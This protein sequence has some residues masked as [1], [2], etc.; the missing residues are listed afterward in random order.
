MS[1]IRVDVNQALRCLTQVEQRTLSACVTYGQVAANKMVKT[2]KQT[3]PW[4]DHTHLA[5]NSLNGGASKAGAGRVRIEL[6]H[7][8]HYGVYLELKHFRHKGN[9]AIVFPTVK[10]MAPEIIRGWGNVIRRG[11]A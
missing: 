7:G 4:T 8:I 11:G 3:R 2:A 9:L 6:A 10:K 1:G 5:K